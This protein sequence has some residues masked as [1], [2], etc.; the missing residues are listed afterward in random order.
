MY[1]LYLPS[2][3]NLKRNFITLYNL[4]LIRRSPL[5]I[6]NHK[7]KTFSNLFFRNKGPTTCN[8]TTISIRLYNLTN[9]NNKGLQS[10]LSLNSSPGLRIIH[11]KLRN[12]PKNTL[13]V[14]FLKNSRFSSLFFTGR[15]GGISLNDILNNGTSKARLSL[16]LTI[17]SIFP[18]KGTYYSSNEG[19]LVLV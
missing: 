16:N 10:E 3:F 8:A 11:P 14:L 19:L 9:Y 15:S 13:D 1:N 18:I 6:F 2:L 5:T 7:Y 12:K 17:T 4:L